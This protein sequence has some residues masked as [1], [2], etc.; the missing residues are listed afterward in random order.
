MYG[1]RSYLRR[2]TVQFSVNNVFDTLPP[3]DAAAV[4]A[5]FFYS[6]YGNIRL[7]DFILRVKKDF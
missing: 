1:E 3:F 5:P 7:R 2:V 6:R 4:R